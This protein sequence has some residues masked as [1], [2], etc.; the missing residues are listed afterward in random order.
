MERL[1]LNYSKITGLSV[2]TQEDLALIHFKARALTPEELFD[3]LCIVPETLSTHERKV[4]DMAYRRGR[5]DG[6]ATATENLFNH[7][8]TKAGGSSCLAYLQQLSPTFKAVSISPNSSQSSGFQ[9]NVIMADEK[10]ADANANNIG[11]SIQ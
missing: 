3:Y 2:L 9:F 5:A 6:I 7:M 11:S 10:T 4:F 1:P 8:K